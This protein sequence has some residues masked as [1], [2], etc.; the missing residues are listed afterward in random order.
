[1]PTD[2]SKLKPAR[3]SKDRPLGFRTGDW[4]VSSLTSGGYFAGYVVGTAGASI[5]LKPVRKRFEPA[6]VLVQLD[7]VDEAELVGV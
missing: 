6:P 1:M 4:L 7:S 2:M 3:K 5:L